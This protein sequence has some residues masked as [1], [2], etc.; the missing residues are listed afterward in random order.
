MRIALF[1]PLPPAKSGIADYSAALLEPLAKLAEVSVNALSQPDDIRVY[2]LGNNPEHEFV[3]EAALKHPGVVVL[4]EANLHYLIAGLTLNGGDAEAYWREVEENGGARAAHPDYRI[5]MLRSI[6]LRSKAAIVHSE[7]VERVLRAQGFAR[8]IARIP[9]GAWIVE[10]TKDLRAQYRQKLG[11]NDE[12]LFGVFGFLKPYKR[13]R[14]I[15]RAFKRLVREQPNVR[16]IFV[17]EK[18]PELALDLP[19][20]ARLIDFAPSGDFTG[21][22]AACDAIL[23][24]RFPTVGESSGTLMRAFG[25]GKASVVSDIGS[26]QELP[27]DVCLKVPID[28]DEDELLLAYLRLLTTRVDVRNELGQRALAWAKRE[29]SWDSVARRYL[30]FLKDFETDSLPARDE[31]VETHRTRLEKTLSMIPPGGPNDW[32]LEMG[33]YMQIT[34]ALHS[35]LGYGNVRGSYFGPAGKRETRSVDVHGGTFECQIDHFDAEKDFYPYPSAH[36]LTVVCCELLEHLAHDPMHMLEQLHRIVRPG[37]HLV[38]TTPNI[39]S[40]RAAA[41]VLQ[42][43]HPMLFPSYI[44]NGSDPRHAREYTPDEIRKLLENSGFE[45][46]TLETG[47]FRDEL[48]PEYGWVEHI[49]D[50]YMLPRVNRGE[51]IYAVGKKVGAMRERYPGWLYA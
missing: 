2:Q 12:P 35:R 46:V 3:Y 24:L 43:H 31:Y 37:G 5:P 16:L 13:I 1:S 22:M 19:P 34:P 30:T 39:T 11:L 49:L 21:Y 25:L 48:T 14:E 41:A 6:L 7:A 50:K 28:A 18:H 42:G 4:H 10:N 17:G 38:L 20:E 32:I 8:P 26:F 15:L 27:D 23:N 9:H 45:V 33:A 51:C 40:L 29:C 36:F 47:P 44:K